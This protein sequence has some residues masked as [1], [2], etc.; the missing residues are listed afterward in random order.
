MTTA[1]LDEDL[2]LEHAI[3]PG[4][5]DRRRVLRDRGHQLRAARRRSTL[6]GLKPAS[7][8]SACREHV[9]R[10][11][12]PMFGQVRS[13]DYDTGAGTSVRL[14][15]LANGTTKKIADVRVGDSVLATDP[16]TG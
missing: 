13:G 15:C 11:A 10:T 16:A 4:H 12:G 3:A 5:D 6:A 8:R 1:V 14:S 7:A 9:R 2:V